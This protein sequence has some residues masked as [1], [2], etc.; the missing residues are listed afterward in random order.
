MD[1]KIKTVLFIL[2]FIPYAVVILSGIWGAVFGV[3]FLFTKAYKLGGFILGALVSLCYMIIFPIIPVCAVFHLLCLLR[4]IVP[5]INNISEKEF[6]TACAVICAAVF[7]TLLIRGYSK[8]FR[9]KAK[10]KHISE[11]ADE[12]MNNIK[13]KGLN[14]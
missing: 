10:A 9:R 12:K 4:K 13:Q 2:T 11:R 7:I 3:N 6:D 14:L 1:P 5:F 8:Y